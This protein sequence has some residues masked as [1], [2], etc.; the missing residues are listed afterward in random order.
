[1]KKLILLFLV[2]LL[3]TSCEKDLYQGLTRDQ[4]YEQSFQKTFGKIAHTQTWGFNNKI[5][6]S[7]Y[8]NGNMWDFIPEDITDT[9]REAVLNVFNNLGEV[10]YTSLIDLDKFYVQ[11]VYKGTQHYTAGNGSDVIGSNHMDWLFTLTDKKVNVVSWWPYEEEIVT[12]DPY[13]DHIFDFNNSNSSDYNGSMLMINSNT[14]VFGFHDSESNKLYTYFR[15]EEI[16]GNYY[17]GFDYSAE[18]DN[19]NQQIQRNYIYNDW[20]VKIIPAEG[21]SI[22]EEGRIIC[23]DMGTIGDFDFN[24]VVFDATI[25]NDGTTKITLL[26]AGGTLDVTVDGVNVGE[27]MGKMVNTGLTN[28]NNYVFESQN[29]YNT[30]IEIPIVVTRTDEAGNVTSYELSAEM[31]KAPQKICVPKTFRWC[32]EYKSIKDAYPGFTEWVTGGKF[33]N[34]EVNNE[35]IY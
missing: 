12:V 18:G 17:V 31:G 8:P 21:N 33:W 4:V 22:K 29:K 6:R 13:P 10:S 26:A 30:L 16:N 7:A 28:V 14:D 20:I 9:E 23:E 5:T 2:G 3:V 11:Q 15:M 27:V 32:K 1:M 19:P 24:D 35:L 34:G 25:Y